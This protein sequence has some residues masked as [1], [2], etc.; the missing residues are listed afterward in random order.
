M[1]Y[2]CPDV[3]ED[4][5]RIIIGVGEIKCGSAPEVLITKALGSCIGLTLWDRRLKRGGMAHVMLP[6]TPRHDISGSMHRFAD[7]AV[8]ALIERL[9]DIGC[10][11][12]R[13][14]AK[15]AGG[16]A[17]FRGDSGIETIGER[18]AKAVLHH[19]ERG[20]IPVAASDTGGSHARTIELSLDTGMLLV[21]SYGREA[22][23]I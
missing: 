12:R 11:K 22:H 16:S 17:M 8:P 21:R 5:S 15:L 20:G 2:V 7:V 13:L 19:L 18:N 14:V 4:P 6:A 3:D 1:M 9:A 23:E 10:E